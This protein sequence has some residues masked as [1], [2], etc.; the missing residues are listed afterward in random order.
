MDLDEE[1]HSTTANLIAVSEETE[2]LVK[3]VCTKRLLNTVVHACR[4]GM[5]LNF[6]PHMATTGTLQ[7]DSFIKLEIP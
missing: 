7:L 1:D 4:S 5:H 2:S 6:V 3:E